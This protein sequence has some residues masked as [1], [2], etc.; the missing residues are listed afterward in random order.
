MSQSRDWSVFD[1][2]E[3]QSA[4]GPRSGEVAEALIA[5]DGMHCAACAARAERALAGKAENIH[6]NLGGRTLSFRWRPARVAIS[7]ILGALDDA[8]LDPRLLAHEDQVES[9]IRARRKLL[10]RMGVA[11]ICAM[12]VM[13]LAW[14]SYSG[15]APEPGIATLLRWAQ[16]IV[17]TPGVLWA[18][19]PFFAGAW[20]ALRARFLNMDVTIA[21]AVGIAYLASSIRT[22]ANH[23]DLYFDTAT[24]FVW[25]LLAGRFLEQRTR[26][27]AGE[28]LRLLAGRRALTAQRRIATGVETVP[29]AALVAG[30]IAIVAPG[31]ALPADGLLLEMEAELDESLLTGEANPVL[32]RPG[33]EV[34]AG[35]LNLGSCPLPVRVTRT[36]TQS[37]LAQITSLLDGAQQGKPRAQQ[38]ADRYAGHF[39][40]GVMLIAAATFAFK[41]WL[42]GGHDLDHALAASLAVLVASC[43]CALSLALPIVIAAANSRL[44][45]GGV[46]VANPDALNRL[47]DVDAALFDK[48]G[49]L[50]RPQLRLVQAVPLAELATPQCL[51]L[52]AA[53][54]RDSRHPLASAFAP[55]AAALETTA[56]EHLPGVGI[57]GTVSGETYWI[58]SAQHAPFAVATPASA[59][60]ARVPTWIVLADSRRALACFAVEAELR[61]E[62]AGAIAELREL[63]VVPEIA[64]GDTAPATA[65]LA[66]ALGLERHR[67]RQT[68][69]DKLARLH[70]LQQG[71]ARVLA[72]G[73]G[74]NDAPL[75][76]AAD[77]S[78]AMP[79]GA[80]L[81]QGK[82]DLI[83]VGDSLAGLPFAIRIAR[84]ARSRVR[85]NLG[86][87]LAYNLAVLP[88]AASGA[89]APW[90]AAAGM[91][92]SSLVVAANALRLGA[93]PRTIS[94]APTP[95][96][97]A[98]AA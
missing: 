12:Q 31:E 11:T 94:P 87:A 47:A 78:A 38:I 74:I 53:L 27:V 79:Q 70:Q 41:L 32:H 45:A 56:V 40:L 17:A 30:D 65:S 58:G 76:A 19:W 66:E 16:W 34:P 2:A 1:R 20:A 37:T 3:L 90:Q 67:A 85:E 93:K 55:H 39:V 73:D 28:R 36:G 15:A 54:E 22:F 48:T 29:I 64:S 8:G 98:E 57:R 60:G 10:L 91:S 42:G 75:L 4:L 50:T 86:W 77:V 9:Q 21:L 80:A 18:G 51:A 95:T 14:P 89:L 88:L 13:M 84:A 61:T 63:G 7:A 71:G 43:P 62:A 23:G 82:A 5:L 83:L 49:T 26:A 25:F 81:T 96:R 52:A 33:D 6:V 46:L 69:A 44:A 92:V 68:P 72:V 59:P 35:S 24:M 97:T